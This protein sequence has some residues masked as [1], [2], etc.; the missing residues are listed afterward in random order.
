ME[1]F[2]I[3][4][5]RHLPLPLHRYL[6]Q[7]QAKIQLETGRRISMERVIYKIIREK[8]EKEQEDRKRAGGG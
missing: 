4:P 2:K 6:V 7:E 5:L 8:I 3:L 1:D